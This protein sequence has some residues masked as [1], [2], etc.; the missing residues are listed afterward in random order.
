MPFRLLNGG[1]SPANCARNMAGPLIDLIAHPPVNRRLTALS[2]GRPPQCPW[3]REPRHPRR[4]EKIIK[5]EGLVPRR[6]YEDQRRFRS[7]RPPVDRG[8]DPLLHLPVLCWTDWYDGA[9]TAARRGA[10]A[11]R[12][13][14]L[15]TGLGPVGV[16][17]PN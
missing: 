1:A 12:G 2:V 13:A 9:A 17:C 8:G 11:L 3:D 16:T 14:V 4:P 6:G 15:G 5:F 10:R 7:N